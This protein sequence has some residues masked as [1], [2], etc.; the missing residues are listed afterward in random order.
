MEVYERKEM[1]ALF[2]E[3]RS[4]LE[5]AARLAQRLEA[6]LDGAWPAD[7]EGPKF[8]YCAYCYKESCDHCVGR[9]RIQ[10]GREADKWK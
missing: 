3:W 2:D 8:G 9:L 10:A 1:T 4:V 7:D 5:K 6:L